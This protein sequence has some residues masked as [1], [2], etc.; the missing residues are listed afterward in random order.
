M[1]KYILVDVHG[2]LTS[3][4]EKKDFL[5]KMEKEYEINSEQ[6]NSLW[7]NHINN[8]DIGLETAADYLKIFNQT[9]NINISVDKYFEIFLDQI[10]PNKQLLKK[11]VSFKNYQIFIVSD[12]L[13]NLS[14]GLGKIFGDDFKKYKK[15]YSFEFGLTK[16]EGL[17][18]IVLKKIKANPS[19]CLFIDDSPKNIQVAKDLGINTLLFENNQKLLT[20][21]NS[22]LT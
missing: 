1:I 15:F 10:K 5:S 16:T 12:N 3:G 7:L 9:F 21:L 19:E 8:F 11:L 17:L 14:R 2:V 18:K 13:V 20:E 6:H 4:D 22:F